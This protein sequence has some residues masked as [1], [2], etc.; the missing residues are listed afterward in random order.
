MCVF[1]YTT[2]GGGTGGTG[3]Q[4]AATPTGAL[5][6]AGKDAALPF[7]TSFSGWLSAV[8]VDALTDGFGSGVGD[9]LTGPFTGMTT[10]TW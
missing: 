1:H 8:P 4:G 10:N 2:Y 7:P 5:C 3:T 6:E 9:T